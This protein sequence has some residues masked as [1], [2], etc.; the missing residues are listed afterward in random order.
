M[1]RAFWNASWMPIWIVK[2][3]EIILNINLPCTTIWKA[4]PSGMPSD[5]GHHLWQTTLMEWPLI[6]EQNTSVLGNC[7]ALFPRLC[8]RADCITTLSYAIFKCITLWIEFD[9]FELKTLSCFG[10]ILERLWWSFFFIAPGFHCWYWLTGRTE[11]KKV[12]T[13]YLPGVHKAASANFFKWIIEQ[14][15][16]M[17][18]Y[19]YPWPQISNYW[20]IFP[21]SFLL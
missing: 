20:H 19:I 6:L 7:L 8:F 13:S 15:E 18:T 12:T 17:A 3:K 11:E 1:N 5:E 21:W 9:L 14:P 2:N 10:Y 4:L 16:V